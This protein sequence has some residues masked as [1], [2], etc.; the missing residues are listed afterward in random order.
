MPKLEYVIRTVGERTEEV[1]I[2]LVK[3]QKEQDESLHVIREN[4]HA[5]AVDKT[6][7]IGIDC[8]SE[9]LVAIDADMLIIPGALATIRSEIRT[10]TDNTA[11]IHPAV[12][13]KLYRMKR[14][15]LTVYRVSILE[16]LYKEFQIIRKKQHLKIE[17]AAIKTISETYGRDVI[18]SKSVTAIHD[19]Y[20]YYKDLYRKAY[21]NA[22]RNPGFNSG[23]SRH[24]KKLASS[25]Q[26]YRVMFRAM[27][28]AANEKRQLQNS[29]ED[30]DSTELENILRSLGLEEKSP[31]DWEKFVDQCFSL[32]VESELEHLAKY[33]IFKDYFEDTSVGNTIKSYLINKLSSIRN[34]H[35]TD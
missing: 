25:D 15:G 24:W 20:Q 26:D 29:V 22:L 11:I 21:L 18:F 9:W 34:A 2:E 14:W 35:I 10:S 32:T 13:D 16:Q 4:T 17:G 23:A 28:D 27:Q 1:C 19:F 3:R 5:K 31:L 30:F 8:Q 6:L 12:V 33:R 7:S